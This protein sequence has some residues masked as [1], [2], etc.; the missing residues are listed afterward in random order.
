[1]YVTDTDRLFTEHRHGVFRFLYRLVG[2]P[3]PARD[4]TQEVFLRVARSGVPEIG[5][6]GQRAWI[7]RVARNLGLN[8]LRDSSRRPTDGFVV[9]PQKGPQQELAFA[10]SQALRQLADLDRDVFL[11]REESGLSYD[12]I[13]VACDLTPTAVRSRL[14][15]AR[16]QLRTAL[17]PNLG[18]VI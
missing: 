8:F 11:L 1:V 16:Q 10:L 18:R 12:E 9:E 17:A 2:Q 13:A 4:L 6:D 14:F 15:R 7:Y 5:A 3:E